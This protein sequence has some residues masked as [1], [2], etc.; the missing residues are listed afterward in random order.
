MATE[1]NKLVTGIGRPLLGRVLT[2]DA[3]AARMREVPLRRG[4]APPVPRPQPT[5]TESGCG[6]G[7]APSPLPTISAAQLAARI[8]GGE[9]LAVVD[10]RELDEQ[11]AGAIPGSRLV[12]LSTL[13]SGEGLARIP[14]D[15]PVVLHC[16][17]GGRSAEALRVLRAAGHPDAAHLAGGIQAWWAYAAAEAGP[18]AANPVAARPS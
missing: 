16:S 13:R 9:D 4:T 2:L 7:E 18:V 8:A 11:A 1:A 14:R 15:R 6:V 12:P 10:V 5:G 3:L 17:A